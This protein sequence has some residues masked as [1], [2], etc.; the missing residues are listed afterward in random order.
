MQEDFLFVKNVFERANA[1][2]YHYRNEA[3]IDLLFEQLYQQIPE[4]ANYR[5][6]FNLIW[7]YI[8]FTGS[9][10]NGLSIPQKLDRK[11]NKLPIFFPVPLQ[12]IDGGLYTNLTYQNIPHGSQVLSVNGESGTIF[13][14]NIAQYTSTDGGNVSGKYA[15]IQTDWMAFYI[16]LAYGASEKFDIELLTPDGKHE[17][18]SWRA[19]DYV[20]YYLNHRKRF[21]ASQEKKPEQD[22]TFEMIDSIGSGLLTI[23]TFSLGG[24]TSE[25]HKTYHHFLDSVMQKANDQELEYLIVD[26]RKNGGGT[27]P[28]DLLT[29]SYLTNRN[30]RENTEAFT[31]F[32]EV[33]FP[34][35]YVESYRGDRKEL[36]EEL[37]E[38]HCHLRDGKYYQDS[39]FNRLWKPNK[40][41]FTGTVVLLVD[42]FVASAASLFASLV[43]S[44]PT[45]V[46]IGEETLGGYYGHTGHI[47]VSYTLP[48]SK[49]ELS[50]SI[51]DLKQDVQTL[52]DE[53]PLDGIHPDISVAPSLEDYFNNRDI[54]LLSAI[55][56]I[57][58][59]TVK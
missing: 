35:N 39:T 54:Q 53:A 7:T 3:E 2:L 57:Q 26:I 25:E 43:K 56:Y 42:P 17:T 31:I 51:V 23:H 22:Y 10:H 33:P 16:Y 15:N 45:S 37:K 24:P 30:F 21:S 1:G 13:A 9:C 38:E 19:V 8:D 11:L 4:S 40:N 34:K 12:W 18:V 44:D 52:P 46:V 20:A 49:M 47:P 36:E 59:Q 50:F 6:F 29:Y 27:D 5:E 41:A 28:N 14:K 58:Q 55:R 32:Q 48:N